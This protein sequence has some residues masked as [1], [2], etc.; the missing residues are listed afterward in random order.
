[1][2]SYFEQEELRRLAPHSSLSSFSKGRIHNEIACDM[3]TCFQRDRDRIIHSKSF[4]RLKH[5]T[6]V[7][8]S[9]HSDHVRSRLT[10]TL[11]VAQISRHL[12]R[13]LKCNEDLAECIAL[14]HD[15]GHTPFGHSGETVLNELMRQHGG[16]EHN[17]QSRRIVTQL[18]IRYPNFNGLNLSIEVLDG[19]IK[20]RTPW[21]QPN[22]S[23]SSPT[24]EAQ[25]V[26][27]ADEIAYNNHDID[28]AIASSIITISQLESEVDLWRL[29]RREA[30]SSYTNLTDD[31]LRNIV[32]RMLISKQIRDVFSASNKRLSTLSDAPFKLDN[33]IGFSIEM[34]EMNNQLRQFLFRSFYSHPYVQ[35]TN[36]KGQQIIEKLYEIYLSK[37]DLI[38]VSFRNQHKDTTDNYRLI[39][40]YISG[41]TDNFAISEY[42]SISGK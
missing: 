2:R 36:E 22:C 40:D 16:F 31:E 24:I 17:Q 20:H 9:L 3:R 10:H 7:F 34:E 25:I 19:L 23:I 42:F 41:M 29:A 4:R 38:P 1:M 30:E 8:L 39:C 32:N 13:L 18:E 11:E 5:K 15:L 26:N 12:S 33:T 14:S 37:T 6:Q 21:D 35:K 28:D 27:L